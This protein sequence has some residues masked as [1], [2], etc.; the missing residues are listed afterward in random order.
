[1]IIGIAGTIGSGKGTVVEY[2]QKKGFKDYSSSGILK[3]MLTERGDPHTREYMADLAEE[4]IATHPG[5]ILSI[6]LERA[7]KDGAADFILE[8]I[9]RQSEADFVRRMGGKILGID[10]DIQ[11]RYARTR[12]RNEGEKDAVTLE[13]FTESSAREDEGKRHLTSN[14][15]SVIETAD[16]IILNNGTLDELHAEIEQALTKLSV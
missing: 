16:A 9:H 15:A 4:L 1:M 10:A 2:L 11:L 6:S 12:A 8:A 14:I 7:R 5:G 3:E 13:Q